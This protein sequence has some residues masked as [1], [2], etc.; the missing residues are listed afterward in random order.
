MLMDP[1]DGAYIKDSVF[2]ETGSPVWSFTPS[3]SNAATSDYENNYF[4]VSVINHRAIHFPNGHSVTNTKTFN[5]TNNLIRLTGNGSHY[6]ILMQQTDTDYA[7]NVY[8]NTIVCDAAGTGYAYRALNEPATTLWYDNIAT[9]CANG[10]EHTGSSVHDYNLAYN[11]STNFGGSW[12]AEA[13]EITTDPDH[14]THDDSAL[15]VPSWA[16][17]YHLGTSSNAI[18]AGS[19]T[20]S[21]AGMDAKHAADTGVNDSGTVDIGHHYPTA[22]GVPVAD[23]PQ[24]QPAGMRLNG[25]RF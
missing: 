24:F 12:S 8:N 11:N 15:G 7:I 1:V 2:Y 16:D 13:N 5:I 6:G 22:A 10:F 3:G 23:T 19:Q 17:D 21:A 14:Q 9:G 25:V 18:D 20:A 4:Y